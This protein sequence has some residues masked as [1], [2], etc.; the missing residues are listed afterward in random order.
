MLLHA[1]VDLKCTSC[2]YVTK[3]ELLLKNHIITKHTADR[4]WKCE[5]C[6]K[7]FK[8][9]RALTVH[10]AQSHTEGHKTGRTCEFCKKTFG[11]S[12]NYY[13]HRKNL[14]AEQLAASLLKKSEE[15]KLRR[16]EVGLESS[17]TIG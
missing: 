7:T 4:P 1:N 16:I 11:S 12:T 15:Q 9:K 13:T 17:M 3:K 8:V 2:D 10:K 5:E 14:H 6:G